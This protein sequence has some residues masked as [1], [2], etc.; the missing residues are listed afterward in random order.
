[1]ASADP[2]ALRI[3]CAAGA[4][5]ISPMIYGVAFDF[6]RDARDA[7]VW[8]MRPGARRWGGNPASRFNWRDGHAWN[9]ASDW[10][11]RNVNYTGRDAFSYRDFLDSNRVRGVA[12]SLTVP[13]L[14]WVAAADSGHSFSVRLD[15][16]Q[17]YADPD[18]PDA[19]N[20]VAADGSLIRVPPERASVPSSPGS[21]G[22]WAAAIRA[23]RD[24]GGWGRDVQ[25]YILDNEPM[26]WNSTHRDVHPEPVSYDELLERTIRY[27]TA[28]RRA[29][30]G[31]LIAGPAAWGW[32]GYFFSAVDAQ[33]GFWLRPDRLRHGNVPLLPWY[34]RRL[35]EHERRTGVRVL[36]VVDVHF[37]PMGAGVGGD[38]GARDPETAA[39]RIRA[40][41]ALWDSTYVDES[42]IDEPVRLIPRLREWI[43]RE[44]PGRGI[45]IGEWSFGAPTHM[46]GGLA[47][48]E[49]LGRF[50]QLG[51]HSAFYWTYPP[52]DSPAFHAFRA[53]RDYDGRGAAFLDWSVPTRAAPG[54]SLF[55]SRDSAATRL[56][57]VLLN[58]D[59]ERAAVAR[60]DHAS[61]GTAAGRRLFTYAGA[62]GG[63]R[64][65]SSV[66]ATGAAFGVTLPPYSIN[67]VEITLARRAGAPRG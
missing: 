40:T 65:D 43:A 62:A 47:A 58:P 10:Y 42:W 15:G 39:R 1:A 63:L 59:P 52:E 50:G 36:D 5:P 19:G 24:S 23:R 41:R 56:V 7:Y 20:G 18:V 12:T 54:L 61:C 33:R 22:A 67:V 34:L 31:A 6:M 3:D 13:M 38:D 57:A 45:S 2:G 46:S 25:T 30:P 35:R 4:R 14:D 9:M 60:V 29:D 44:Y 26:L 53:F 49:A 27:G 64:P 66:A 48:A 51:L 8:R 55:A 37:Y 16:A 11:F 21:V 32:P 28:I 17:Q